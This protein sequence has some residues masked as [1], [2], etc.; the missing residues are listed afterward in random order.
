M[1]L[2]VLFNGVSEQAL[3]L[4]FVTLLHT[5]F[6]GEVNSTGDTSCTE[7]SVDLQPD[8]YGKGEVYDLYVDC[9]NYVAG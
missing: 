3:F 8:L 7:M 9:C 6:V 2:F 5:A 4:S 1:K